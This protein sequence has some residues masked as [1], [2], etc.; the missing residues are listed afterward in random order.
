MSAV[1]DALIEPL[2]R[3]VFPPPRLPSLT[4]TGRERESPT[5]PRRAAMSVLSI[6]VRTGG[7]KA[8]SSVTIRSDPPEV[9][10]EG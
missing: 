6:Y 9:K 10:P 8:R 5:R 4:L 2:S 3:E 1:L 7:T